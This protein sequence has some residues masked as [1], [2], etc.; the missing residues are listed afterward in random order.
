[1][2]VVA[3]ALIVLGFGFVILAMVSAAKTVFEKA[4]KPSAQALGPFDPDA[5]A[6]LVTAVVN[7]VKVAPGWLLLATVGCG[8]IAWGTTML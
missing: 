1:M 6:K 8:M 5:W 3:I 2:T 7:F 4:T